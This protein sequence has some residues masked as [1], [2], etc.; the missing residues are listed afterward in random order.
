MDTRSTLDLLP[1]LSAGLVGVLAVSLLA[2]LVVVRWWFGPPAPPARHWG[3]IALRALTLLTLVAILLNP[4]RVDESPGPIERARVVYLVDASRSMSL[5][6]SSTR[7]DDA[8]AIVRESWRQ[9]PAKRRPEPSVYRFGEGLSA[10]DLP[11]VFEVDEAVGAAATPESRTE[12]QPQGP[13][14]LD[15]QLAGALRELTGR[16]GRVVPRAVVL[17]SDGQTRD[18]TALEETC[19]RYASMGVPIHAVPLGTADRKGDVAIVGMVVPARVRKQS[20]QTAQVSVRSY[21]YDG[22]RSELIL[23]ALGEDGRPERQL[24]RLPITLDRGPPVA[25][26]DLPDRRQADADSSLDRCAARRGVDRQ[27]P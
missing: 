27:Q 2:V 11:D 26:V 21:G 5:G 24:N 16:F 10:T 12:S 15:T 19:R 8:L 25:A 20:Q 6:G 18:T 9:I 22:R 14:D 13:T 17:L 23:S 3:L 7:W 4:I 1:P